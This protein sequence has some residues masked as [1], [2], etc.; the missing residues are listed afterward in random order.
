MRVGLGDWDFISIEEVPVCQTAGGRELHLFPENL[1]T[2][3][4]APSNETGSILTA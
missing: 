3:Q 2:L 1:C 4:G